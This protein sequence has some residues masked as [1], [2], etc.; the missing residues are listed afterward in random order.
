MK[1]SHLLLLSLL[2]GLIFIVGWPVNG[3]PGFLFTAFVPL[4]FIEDYILK[5][6]RDFSR[7]S[8]FFYTYPALLI[9]NVA[10]TWWIWNS[11]PAAIAAWTL[12]AMLMGIVFNVYHLTRRNLS[13]GREGYFFL[14]FYWISFE[15]IH[16]N[17]D[18]TWTWLNVGNGFSI[19]YKWVQWYE[20]TGVLGG[21]FWVLA[22]N[23]LIFKSLQ[24]F[25]TK[26]MKKFSYQL[27]F[28]LV[29]LLVPIILSFIMYSIYEETKDPVTVVVCQPNI[30]PYTEQYILPATQ[31]VKMNLALATP[32]LDDSVRFVISPESTLQDYLWEG[33]LQQ[34]AAIRKL[35]DFTQNNPGINYVIGASTYKR[36]AD[37][38]VLPSTVRFHKEQGFYYDSYNTTL[39]INKTRK[40]QVRHKSKLVPGVE[41]MPSWGILK[42]VEKYA[43]DLGGTTGTLGKDKNPTPFVVDDTL[44]IAPLVCYE[45]IFGEY[46]GKFVQKGAQA[47]FLITNDGWWGDT[48]GYKQHLSFSS[49]RALEMRRDIARSANTGVSCFVDQ[50]GDIQQATAYWE[51]AAIRQNI[52]LN[53]KITFYARYGDYFG[54]I[55]GFISVI[56]IL[57]S[58][59]FAL[60]GKKQGLY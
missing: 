21:T 54:R 56:F 32:L 2:S 25:L 4:L 16:L 6:K 38:A 37:N 13:K 12:N 26:E 30:D 35:E 57:L 39:L 31:V 17:W 23:I 14:V 5:N 29:V 53:D 42:F 8:V 58:I 45:S 44:K 47:F 18:L 41:A 15:Y 59:V 46:C 51:P 27:S 7:F 28:S 33:R 19:Y 11:T 52:N 24:F 10:T 1:K 48:P 60:R 34:S 3:F 9:W 36:Y 55:S 49:L 50:R 20:F 43:I 40:I 22:V